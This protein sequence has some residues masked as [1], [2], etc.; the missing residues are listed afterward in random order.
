MFAPH[1]ELKIERWV[2]G[3]IRADIV[4]TAVN[5]QSHYENTGSVLVYLDNG[6]VYGGRRS[7]FCDSLEL[8]YN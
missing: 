8:Y 3:P 4:G 6:R 5:E 7:E 2:S 1:R